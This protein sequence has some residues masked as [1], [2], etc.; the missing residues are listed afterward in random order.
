MSFAGGLGGA[1]ISGPLPE[2]GN[3]VLFGVPPL[4]RLTYKLIN[5][6]D[7]K[8][9]ITQ[10]YKQVPHSLVAHKGPA[11]YILYI[12]YYILYIIYYI[13]C[14]ARLTRHRAASLFRGT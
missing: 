10:S 3:L 4:A 14:A 5:I 9:T 12:V 8:L 1:R 11:D 6:K 7:N 13:Q 2:G